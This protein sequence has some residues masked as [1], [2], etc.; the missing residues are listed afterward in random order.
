MQ[1]NL[2]AAI[3]TLSLLFLDL[4][5]KKQTNFFLL[6]QVV[7]VTKWPS[8]MVYRFFPYAWSLPL[9]YYLMLYVIRETIMDYLHK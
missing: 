2:I 8:E 9:D 4:T 7:Y 3:E 5:Q 6:C 1:R